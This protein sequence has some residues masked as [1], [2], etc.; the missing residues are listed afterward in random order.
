MKQT[1]LKKTNRVV[2]PDD[3]EQ[4]R[5]ERLKEMAVGAASGK[6]V[7]SITA[8]SMQT[9]CFR[10]RGTAPLVVNRFS[11]KVKD[12]IIA[13]MCEGSRMRKGK[14]K[15]PLKPDENIW[16]PVTDPRKAGTGST[17][18]QSGAP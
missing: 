12:Q 17:L 4:K 9:A 10:I 13:D 18:Q 14:K 11:K 8:P 16:K 5:L 3:G 7:V 1:Q 15:E 2:F 6:R